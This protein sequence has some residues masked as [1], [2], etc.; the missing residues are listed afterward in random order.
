[1]KKEPIHI[2]KYRPYKKPRLKILEGDKTMEGVVRNLATAG[3]DDKKISEFLG[4]RLAQLKKR[5][6]EIPA[7]EEALLEGRSEATQSMVAQV[8]QVAMGGHITQR[9]KERL[10]H[11]GERTQEI[12]TEEHPPNP[13]MMM[14]W[15]T[16]VAPDDWKYSRQLVKEDNQGLNVDG[17]ILESDKIT[18][19]SREI[20]EGHTVESDGEHRVSEAAAQP[21]REGNR[22]AGDLHPD[23]QREA[24]DNIQ[25]N[26]L[27]VSTE[28][29]TEPVQTHSL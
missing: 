29:G 12:I 3:L 14:F 17:K 9:I 13:Q 2:E 5:L 23:V 25:D 6:K 7:L 19:L 21:A 18:R 4:L 28:T 26:V 10:N 27:D 15:L 24:V 22:D 16:N 11:K 8:F 20:F 1:M